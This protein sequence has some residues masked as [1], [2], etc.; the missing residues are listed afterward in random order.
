MVIF[1][2]IMR[3]FLIISIFL[4]CAYFVSAQKGANYYWIQFAD[5]KGTAY[6][7]SRP[8]QFLSERALER[9]I[10]Q[11]IAVDETDLPVSQVY[12]DSL[13]RMGFQLVHCS[14]WLNGCTVK[15]ES[16]ENIDRLDEPGFIINIE[17]TKPALSVKSAKK[18]FE[19]CM[20]S[21]EVDENEKYGISLDQLVQINGMPL[22]QNGFRGKGMLVAVL[23]NGF[24]NVNSIA[25][26]DSLWVAKRIVAARDFV[27]PVASVFES[28]GHGTNVLSVMGAN[29]PGK[30]LGVAPDASYAL[31]R[32][33]DDGSEFLIEEDNWV[34]GAEYA[35]SLGA[36]IINSSLGYSEFDDETMDHLYSELDG[37]TTRVTRA[38]NLAAQKGMLVVNS[39]GNEGNKPWKYIIAPSD[40]ENVLAIGAVDGNGTVAS[41]S[42]FGPAYGGAVKPNVSARGVGTA[43]L[44]LTGQ[45]YKGNGTSFSS[46]LV[47]GM[48]ACLWQA[49][50]AASSGEIRNAIEKT[51]S[52]FFS[53]DDRLGYGIPDFSV[54][55]IWLKKEHLPESVKDN[56]WLVYPNPVSERLHMLWLRESSFSSCR[57]QLV[58]LQGKILQEHFFPSGYQI[59]LANLINLPSGLFLLKITSEETSNTFK[60]IKTR[61]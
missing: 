25:A 1:N 35:D 51:A 16:P 31:I 42:S 24:M 23:D 61:L 6:S 11:Q 52:Q 46:P 57:V 38:A 2:R 33:E 49:N 53:P 55:D 48:A 4:L 22:H 30:Y 56:N 13:V 40:G 14:K 44:G 10:R 9:R 60:L 45:I 28:G 36:D 43:L 17:I 39:A 20:L 59:V 58:S 37:E 47:A 18:K 29:S 34:V 3:S 19:D 41:F 32:T 27:S 54:A 12:T 26:F 5:K 15:T 50:P 7:I 8:E 21:D